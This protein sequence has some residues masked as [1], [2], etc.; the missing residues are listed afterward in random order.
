M[1][2][3]T[4]KKP[5]GSELKK[6]TATENVAD[7]VMKGDNDFGFYTCHAE[8]GIGAAT[9]KVVLKQISELDSL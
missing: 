8:N 5:D 6:V 2:V 3:L 4:W 1:P 9:R 7:A